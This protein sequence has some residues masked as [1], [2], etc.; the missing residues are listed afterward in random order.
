VRHG[1]VVDPTLA[2]GEL[3]SRPAG[4]SLREIEPGAARMP[5]LVAATVGR[6]FRGSPAELAELTDALHRKNIELV[7]IL[8][9][10][11]VPVVAGT[12]VVVPGHSLHR[13]LELYVD[14]GMKPI[15]AIQ[16]AT[17]VPARAMGLDHDVG[18]V[19]VGRRADLIV[20]DGDPLREIREIR[21]VRWVIANG[22]LFDTAALWSS[23]GFGTGTSP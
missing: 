15:E 17:I 11:G 8:H 3:H 19:E 4:L 14:A 2:A 9:R 7:G 5:S 16:A 12:D 21:N 10:A 13:E 18:T 20:V 23:A 6:W 1:T 22:R